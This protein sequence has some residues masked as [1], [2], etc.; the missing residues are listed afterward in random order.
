MDSGLLEDA[1]RDSG[2]GWQAA[3]AQLPP[4]WVDLVDR[5]R[6]YVHKL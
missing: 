5:V 2:S 6:I 3:R 1:N 4:V